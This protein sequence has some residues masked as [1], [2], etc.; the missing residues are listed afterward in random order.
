MPKLGEA[1]VV[2][3]ANL[4]P[5]KRG[6]AAARRAVNIAMRKITRTALRAGK[7]AALAFA[8]ISGAAVKLAMDAEESENLFVVSMGNMA[9]ATREWSEEMSKALGLNAYEVRR[10]VSTFNVMLGSMGLGE[11]EAAKMSKQLTQLTYDMASFYNLKPEVAF[12]KL[13]SGISGEIEPLKRLGIL[14]NENTIKTYALTK[15]IIGEKE[16]LSEI[17]KVQARYAVILEQTDKAQGDLA[18][19]AGSATNIMR[20][21]HSTLTDVAIAYGTELLPVV[22]DLAAQLRDWLAENKERIRGWGAAVGKALTV[23][24]D[25]FKEFV[26]LLESGR[27]GKAIKK[28]FPNLTAFA[29]AL[30]ALTRGVGKAVSWTTD[31]LAGGIAKSAIELGAGGERVKLAPAV[32]ERIGSNNTEMLLREIARNTRNDTVE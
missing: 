9:K 30:G 20:S 4:A 18:R 7:W 12:L 3:R 16:Q 14:V 19:T 29:S 22:T 15:G 24:V 31:A 5:L 25:K 1:F 2:V 10:M 11:K 6:L 26:D 28:E 32:A 27:L 13:Q 8:G 17:Q 23:A 21:L